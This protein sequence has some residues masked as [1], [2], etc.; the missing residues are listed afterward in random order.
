MSKRMR[1]NPDLLKKLFKLVLTNR[2][3]E[4]HYKDEDRDFK[5]KRL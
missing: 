1:E 2:N 3:D 5:L 4:I